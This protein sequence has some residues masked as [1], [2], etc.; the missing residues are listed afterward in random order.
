MPAPPPAAALVSWVVRGALCC[1]PKAQLL[2]RGRA[3][4]PERKAGKPSATDLFRDGVVRRHQAGVDL[5]HKGSEMVESQDAEGEVGLRCWRWASGEDASTSLRSQRAAVSRL[6]QERP[7]KAS[8]SA[9]AHSS[10]TFLTPRRVSACARRHCSYFTSLLRTMTI[11]SLSRR[12]RTFRGSPSFFTSCRRRRP[13][14]VRI[15]KSALRRSGWFRA[16]VFIA[17]ELAAVL[18]NTRRFCFVLIA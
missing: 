11:C 7:G 10:D 8:K 2:A 16:A 15:S 6:G 1:P 9:W 18:P 5:H 17:S 4:V 3:A 13:A 14:R 12:L